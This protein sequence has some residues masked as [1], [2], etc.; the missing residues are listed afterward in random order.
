MAHLIVV[1]IVKA[2]SCCQGKSVPNLG[3]ILK[4]DI[5]VRGVILLALPI[6]IDIKKSSF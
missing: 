4:F 5:G 3:T 1:V 6:I 2:V